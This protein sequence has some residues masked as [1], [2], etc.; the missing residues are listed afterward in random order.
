MFDSLVAYVN[1]YAIL[2]KFD[3]IFEQFQRLISWTLTIL[4]HARV[5]FTL[6]TFSII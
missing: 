4:T 3:R 2:S 1:E 6:I 5:V